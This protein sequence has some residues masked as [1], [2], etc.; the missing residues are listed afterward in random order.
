MLFLAVTLL[1]ASAS[2]GAARAPVSLIASP[3]HLSLRGSGTG[4]VG[5]TNSGS[6]SAVV[7]VVRSGLSLDLR[8]R[9]RVVRHPGS[10]L[11]VRPAR[12]TLAPGASASL[13]ISARVPR[14]AE[15]GDHSELVLLTTRPLEGAG[16]SVRMRLGVVVVVR[17]PGK[18]V[19]RLAA[20]RIQARPRRLELVVANRG[21]VTE[22]V[23]GACVR[24]AIRR[25]PRVLARLRPV[26][27]DLMP[28]T[29]GI[30]EI[31][32]RRPAHGRVSA[33][34]EFFPRRTC[35]PGVN[36]AFGLRL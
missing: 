22:R 32:Y 15:P 26:E 17:A 14:R 24:V 11:A 2:A 12:L 25:G 7:D 8:G 18:L 16:L 13:Q 23:T 19:R 28:H 10:W 21:N 3:A 34:V 4:V 20:V 6:R 5:V 30:V 29:S 33:R 35:A 31:P 9:P 27:R 1:A 36:R